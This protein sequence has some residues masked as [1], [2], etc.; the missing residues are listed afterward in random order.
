M[1]VILMPCVQI[2]MVATI[3]LAKLLTKEMDTTV[4]VSILYTFLIADCN[5]PVLQFQA[6][7]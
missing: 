6:L 7:S 1:I 4:R 2:H 3:A 5:D